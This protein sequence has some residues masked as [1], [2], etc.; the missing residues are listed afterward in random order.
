MLHKTIK[1]IVQNNLVKLISN[2]YKYVRG[3]IYE[4]IYVTQDTHFVWINDRFLF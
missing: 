4:Y 2:T 1:C 3:L